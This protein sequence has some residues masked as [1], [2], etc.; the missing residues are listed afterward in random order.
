VAA[1]PA[2]LAAGVCVPQIKATK[3]P[4]MPTYHLDKLD[5]TESILNETVISLDQNQRRC[6]KTKRYNIMKTKYLI[7]FQA[8]RK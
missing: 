4:E 2:V 6:A 1:I 3:T 8:C 5:G 7:R